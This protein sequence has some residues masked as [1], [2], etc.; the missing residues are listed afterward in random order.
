MEFRGNQ[1]NPVTGKENWR[2]IYEQSS[3]PSD[4]YSEVGESWIMFDMNF[5]KWFEVGSTKIT[6]KLEITNLF[7]TKNPAIINPVTGDAYR[8]DYPE[9]QEELIALRDDRSYDVPANV[10]D[11][12]YVDPRDNNSPAYLNPANFLEQRHIMFGL[13]IN[14]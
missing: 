4:R 6:A 3:D 10:R 11:P 12:R 14:F 1:R 5:Q 7:N 13:E 2:P 8:T 9:S